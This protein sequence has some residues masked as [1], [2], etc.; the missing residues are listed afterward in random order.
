MASQVTTRP[1]KVPQGPP[2]FPGC[3]TWAQATEKEA[4]FIKVYS[5]QL[6]C[7]LLYTKLLYFTLF[8]STLHLQGPPSP[9]KAPQ[10]L[11][12]PQGS[13]MTQKA[14]KNEIK[15]FSTLLYSTLIPSAV[16]Y[17]KTKTKE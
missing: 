10:A 17:S 11:K 15:F 2:P 13:N 6:Y 5:I 1:P 7:I 4:Q 9:H 14:P 8:F 12:N 16:L 3:P